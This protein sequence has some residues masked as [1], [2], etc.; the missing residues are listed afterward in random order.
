M[1]EM[2]EFQEAIARDDRREQMKSKEQLGQDSEAERLSMKKLYQEKSGDY[3][4]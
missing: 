4:Y 1:N 2:E 3:S